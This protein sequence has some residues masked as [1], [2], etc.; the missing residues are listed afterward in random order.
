M[1]RSL[2][3]TVNCSLAALKFLLFLIP[4][5]LNCHFKKW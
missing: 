1:D 4:V 3:L 5:K 2:K